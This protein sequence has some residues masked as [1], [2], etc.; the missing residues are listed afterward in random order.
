M[1]INSITGIKGNIRNPK[2]SVAMFLNSE[3]EESR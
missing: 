3:E 1:Y 2:T